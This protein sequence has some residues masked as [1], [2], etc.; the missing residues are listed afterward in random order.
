MAINDAL[1]FV[2]QT[3]NLPVPLHLRNAPTKL[4][5]NMG[6]G[7]NYKYSH[8]FEGHFVDQDYLPKDIR[9]HVFY[10]PQPNAHEDGIRARLK[11]WWAQR[12]GY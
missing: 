12:Y 9:G 6:Y 4:M 2:G 8:D 1:S 10:N 11:N 7:A 3:G 5:E